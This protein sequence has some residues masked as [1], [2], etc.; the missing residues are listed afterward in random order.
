[1]ARLN[2]KR[3][4]FAYVYRMVNEGAHVQLPGPPIDLV[5]SAQKLAA[6]FQRVLMT[7]AETLAL[8][9]QP[10]GAAG[11][12]NGGTLAAGRRAARAAGAGRDARRVP[13]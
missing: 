3:R 2:R 4:D 5:R 6:W 10:P 11:R 9:Q 13:G 8:A 7:P 12:E 1:M